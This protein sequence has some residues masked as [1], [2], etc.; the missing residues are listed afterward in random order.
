MDDAHLQK[1]GVF[2]VESDF[3]RVSF[4]F[5]GATRP[6]FH[7]QMHVSLTVANRGESPIAFTFNTTQRFEI[8][9]VDGDGKVVTRWSDG[10]RFGQIVTTQSLAPHASWRFEG[11][12]PLV[13]GGLGTHHY[14]ARIYVTADLR[15][16]AQSPV[17]IT[18]AP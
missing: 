16:G 11:A 6:D 8:E 13:A 4:L 3:E 9:L 15:P 5:A 17:T 10:Q 1:H 14:T 12:L 18:V 7:P 2:E